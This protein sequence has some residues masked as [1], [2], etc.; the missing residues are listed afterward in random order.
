MSAVEACPAWIGSGNEERESRKDRHTDAHTEKLA[1]SSCSH[2]A[3][4]LGAFVMFKEGN[5][6][7][8]C[9]EVFR[10]RSL[11]CRPSGRRLLQS[12]FLSAFTHGLEE[13]LASS[14]ELEA[15]VFAN[16][17]HS[18]GTSPTNSG[19]LSFFPPSL[20]SFLFSFNVYK[21]NGCCRRMGIKF[22]PDGFFF[23]SV[24][25]NIVEFSSY[26]HSF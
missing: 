11:G 25:A 22:L 6:M 4:N 10:G 2:T 21:C 19:F 16:N 1:Q 5:L 14:R 8:V 24:F 23:L 7:R 9:L 17:T 26:F 18:L 15:L 13:R 20:S 12:G 3:C